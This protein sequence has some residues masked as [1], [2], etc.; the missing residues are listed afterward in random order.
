MYTVDRILDKRVSRKTG[1]AQ[2]L[3]KWNGYS[4]EQSTWE[5]EENLSTVSYMVK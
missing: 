2:Y 5:P 1:K 3:V 4:Q